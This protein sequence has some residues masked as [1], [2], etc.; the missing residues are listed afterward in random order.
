MDTH[1]LDVTNH[2]S[3]RAFVDY[4]LNKYGQ[5]DL[6]VNAAGYGLFGALEEVELDAAKKQLDVNLFGIMDLIK[7]VIPNMRK[8]KH[9]RIINISSLAGQSYTQLSGWYNVSKHAL[10]TM[11][12]VL[13]LE[14]APFGISVVIVEPG[15]TKTNWANVTNQLL[16]KTTK[17]NSPYRKQAKTINQAT[18]TASEVANVIVKAAKTP[19][20][21]IRYQVTLTDKIMMK[22]APVLGYK[23]QDWFANHLMS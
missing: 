18:Q 7:L 11:S 12:D 19:K 1:Q 10:E 3:N 4:V 23:A 20:P 17:P 22:L 8:N 14:L 5:I 13:R 16:L 9:G 15:I 2:E 6:I 21:K